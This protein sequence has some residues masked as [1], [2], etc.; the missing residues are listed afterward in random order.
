MIAIDLGSNTIRFIE[1][2]GE[3]WGKSFE[4]VVRTAESL[5]TTTMIGDNAIKRIIDAINDAKIVINFINQPIIAYTTAAIR[6]AKNGTDVLNIIQEKTGVLFQIIDGIKEGELT[7]LAVRH[8]LSTLNIEPKNFILSDI[9]GGSTELIVVQ[10]DSVKII[11]IPIGIV[12]MSEKASNEDVLSILLDEFKDEVRRYIASLDLAKT[13]DWLVLTAGTPTTIA[14]Y[15][16]GMDYLS[17]NAEKINGSVLTLM[18]CQRSY[19]EL[20]SMEQKERSRY[21][22]VGREML[23]ATGIRIVEALYEAFECSKAIIIDDG[24]REGIA[25]EYFNS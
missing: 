25:L 1:Y 23:I 22:G 4:K 15:V 17:Y 6:M 10:G 19:R 16:A 14:A 7:L 18:D 2:D 21:T 20:M 13:L 9:G 24:L 3:Q 11:S 12:T 5:H 8:R